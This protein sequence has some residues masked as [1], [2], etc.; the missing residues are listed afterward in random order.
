MLFIDVSGRGWLYNPADSTALEI[1][2]FKD[3][4]G[5]TSSGQPIKCALWDPVGDQDGKSRSTTGTQ[6]L[7]FITVEGGQ[8][9][10]YVYSQLHFEGP[11]I[12]R[13]GR[14]DIDA[15]TGDMVQ[16]ALST[17]VPHGSSPAVVRNGR[18]TCQHQSGA[19]DTTILNT[20]SNIRVPGGRGGARNMERLTECFK[21]RLSMLRLKDAWEVAVQLNN[22]SMWLAL[23][24]KSMEHL[25][26]GL[27]KT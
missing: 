26:I 11:T 15:D 8:F 25:D 3:E 16:E 2:N 21:Q 17:D 13:V 18:V 7:S 19:L 20:H 12:T 4:K 24:G 27:G 14:I 9:W 22:R 10:T 5:S 1:P 6:S 23:S